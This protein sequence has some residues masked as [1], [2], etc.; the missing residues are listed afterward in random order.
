MRPCGHFHETYEQDARIFPTPVPRVALGAFFAAVV[1]LPL[2]GSDYAVH[3]GVTS[4][5]F[6]LSATGLTILSGIAGQLSIG[7]GA[8]MGVG[9]YA[10]AILGV[11]FH[12]PFPLAV[13]GGVV[14]TALAGLVVALPSYR[15]RGMY[16]L[17]STL[18]AQV[19][20][21]F[22]VVNLPDWTGGDL[23]LIVPRPW[24]DSA[25]HGRAFFWLTLAVATGGIVYAKNLLRTRVGRALMSVRDNDL[26]ASVLGVDVPRYKLLAFVLCSCYAGLA[27]GLL[28][29]YL[30]V[31]S[32][33][34]FSI[35]MSVQYI[36]MILIG[37]LGSLSGT[38]LG[39]IFVG[40]LPELLSNLALGARGLAGLD[41]T[42][43]LAIINKGLFG[44]LIIAFL[45]GKP[46]GL[47]RLWSDTKRYWK[48]WPFSY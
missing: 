20:F 32:Y 27:G 17:V 45:V 44:L 26:A 16:L 4:A 42:G 13:L 40:L 7:Q 19:L 3:L 28:A 48:L 37:G 24:A 12:W 5:I 47:S 33:E 10:A 18:A 1:T 46:E 34:P 14:I 21:T 36:S 15:I 6:V 9:A 30:G 39:A 8:T 38:V 23:G 22:A 2:W 43:Q 41:L 25:V 11:R 35:T 31:I 29:Y